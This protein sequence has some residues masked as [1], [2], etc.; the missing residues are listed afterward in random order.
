[1]KKKKSKKDLPA[2]PSSQSRFAGM[3][4]TV[5][6]LAPMNLYL[7]HIVPILFEAFL[8]KTKNKLHSN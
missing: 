1:M 6:D 3:A 2:W 7:F 4:A 8:I 5:G